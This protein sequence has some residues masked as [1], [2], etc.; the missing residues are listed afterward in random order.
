MSVDIYEYILKE[1]F[2]SRPNEP[3]IF[4]R[5]CTHYRIIIILRIYYMNDK[6]K[7]CKQKNIFNYYA[8]AH[9]AQGLIY[10][11]PKFNIQ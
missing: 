10:F 2:I 8:V 4:I 1:W 9:C 5:A 6:S 3:F 11:Y 7:R